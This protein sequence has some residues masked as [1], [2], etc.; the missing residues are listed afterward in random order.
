MPMKRRKT[1]FLQKHAQEDVDVVFSADEDS[2][3]SPDMGEDLRYSSQDILQS[4]PGS[5]L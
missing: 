5:I 4:D 1:T 3:L 2:W